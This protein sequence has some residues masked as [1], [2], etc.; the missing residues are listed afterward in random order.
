M[1]WAGL[2]FQSDSPPGSMGVHGIPIGLGQWSLPRSF[3]IPEAPLL[4]SLICW[5]PYLVLQVIGTY[6]GDSLS[7]IASRIAASL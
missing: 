7:A 1:F 3:L 4:P 5:C 6:D 2:T